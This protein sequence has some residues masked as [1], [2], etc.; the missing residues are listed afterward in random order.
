MSERPRTPKGREPHPLRGRTALVTGVSRRAGIGYAIACRLAAYGAN[1]LLHHYRPHD[2][3]QEWGADDLDAV[4]AGV[5]AHADANGVGVADAHADL[6][7]PDAPQ[8]IVDMAVAEFGRLDVLVCNHA[9]SGDD[10]ALGGL[11]AAVLDRHW[12]VDAR[13]C[14]LL[15]QA[16]ASR[17]D[18]RPGGAIVFMTSGQ[19]L[20][21]LPGEVAY[22]AAKA[23]LAG[24]TVTLAD[25]LADQGIRLNTVNPGPVD[26]GYL[27]EEM[28][29]LVAPMFPFGRYGR[30]D[31][32]AR[33][34]AW[35]VTDEAGWITGQ[36]IDSEGGFGRWRPRG[37]AGPGG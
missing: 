9:L 23:A 13:S 30:P 10:A 31:D 29:E 24:V 14:I 21:P 3:D 8:R 7:D 11:E 35:L 5:R 25:Q 22:A 12:A 15:A 26:T 20:G 17:H 33:L 6:S 19:H 2:L 36:V 27:T 4:V 18:G 28:W 32:A 37:P 1:V 16:F 34:I